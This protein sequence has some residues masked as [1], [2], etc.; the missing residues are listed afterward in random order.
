MA[1]NGSRRKQKEEAGIYLKRLNLLYLRIE[2]II[3]GGI[4]TWRAYG[5]IRPLLKMEG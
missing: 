5:I 2:Q 3:M 1:S 4:K